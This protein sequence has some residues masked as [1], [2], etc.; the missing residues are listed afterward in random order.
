MAVVT[1]SLSFGLLICKIGV[2]I[3]AAQGFCEDEMEKKKK[4][5]KSL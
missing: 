3:P 5:E 2:M 1:V 4:D